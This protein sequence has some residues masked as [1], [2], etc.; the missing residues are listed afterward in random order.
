LYYNRREHLEESRRF[1]VESYG[2]STVAPL[3]ATPLIHGVIQGTG[4]A[5]A[6]AA[7]FES[8]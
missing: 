4:L 8:D 2:L 3:R 7:D 6:T 1:I 5:R